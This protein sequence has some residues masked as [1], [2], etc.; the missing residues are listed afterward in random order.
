MKKGLRPIEEGNVHYDRISNQFL[1]EKRIA[2][3]AGDASQKSVVISH[4]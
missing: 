4:E 3:G 1:D 2:T